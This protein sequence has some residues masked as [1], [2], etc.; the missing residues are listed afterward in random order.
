M[1]IKKGDSIIVVS[2]KDRLKK[3][4]VLK[5]FPKQDKVLIE[6]LNLRKK[7]VKPKKSG[8]KGE[9]IQVSVP[10]NVSNVKLICPR[11]SQPARVGCKVVGKNKFRTCKKCYQEI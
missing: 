6:G 3:G 2:G 9:T 11:C 5:V 4:K 8:E 1:K 10:I 7:H